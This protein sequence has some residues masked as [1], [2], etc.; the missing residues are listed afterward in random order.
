MYNKL[1]N[2]SK[3]Q[4]L[5]NV[6]LVAT[7]TAMAQV[8]TMAFAPII[9][10][11]YGP[12]A[13][14]VQGVFL[15]LIGIF[16]PIAALTYPIAIVLPK[17]DEDAK[18]LILIS[19]NV[20]VLLATIV[21]F[22]IVFLKNQIVNLLQIE[23]I[24]Q[25]LYLIPLVIVFSA[26]LQVSQ[27]WLIRTKQFRVT[28]K[29]AFL[30]ALYIN[31]SKVGIGLFYPFASVLVFISTLSNGIQALMLFIGAK[32]SR[33]KGNIKIS[34]LITKKKIAKKYIDFPLY[35]SP[36]VF[37]NAVSQSIPV[38]LLSGLFG[39]TSAGFY[40]LGRT[41]LNMPSQLIGKSVGDV[42]YPRFTEA[43]Y[44]G[45]DYT[46]LLIKSTFALAAVGIIPFGLVITFGPW[47]FEVVF[48]DGWEVAGEYARWIALWSFF[49][50]I[51]QPTVSAIPVLNM[52]GKFLIYEIV[53]L[54]VRVITLFLGFTIYNSE[55][56]AIAFFSLAGVVL[57]VFLITYTIAISK[58]EIDRV[59]LN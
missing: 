10:R 29:V 44:N 43:V 23:N 26:F 46:K 27:Q 4:F 2:L 6:V 28:A 32:R 20:S 25:F 1:M 41:V 30:Q 59:Y 54:C 14:G 52:Q 31:L 57:N 35:R 19:I 50:F 11:I 16:T 3:N 33:S 53:S 13:F 45:E 38:L 7:G 24:A 49:A 8:I 47:L 37:I 22:V 51:N 15:A 5:K 21:T 17:S 58:S 48:G 55:I 12:E 34:P 56:H 9:T 42:F 18:K 39:P 40:S 36:Q